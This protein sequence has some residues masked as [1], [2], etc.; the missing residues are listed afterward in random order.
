MDFSIGRSLSSAYT[1]VKEKSST[2]DIGAIQMFE[3][4]DTSAFFDKFTG[5]DLN[6]PDGVDG[7]A[8]SPA[9]EKWKEVVSYYR[10]EYERTTPECHQTLCKNYGRDC[11]ID[12][13]IGPTLGRR[14][15]YPD[16]RRKV[17]CA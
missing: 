12:Y 11:D 2:Q 14:C 6:I 9:L 15:R 16:V 7:S 1:W 4:P 13:I 8:D 5:I 17:S 3:V 10:N